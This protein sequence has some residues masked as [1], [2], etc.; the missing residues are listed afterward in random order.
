[1]MKNS[2]TPRV[3]FEQE[4]IESELETFTSFF[5]DEDTNTLKPRNQNWHIKTIESFYPELIKTLYS[6]EYSKNATKCKKTIS[7][8]FIKFNEDNKD[9]LNNA[10]KKFQQEWEAYNDSYFASFGELF[11]IS[12]NILNKEIKALVSI[13]PI[14]PRFLDS[15]SFNIYYLIDEDQFLSV[16]AHEV[17]HFLFFKKWEEVFFKGFDEETK[18]NERQKFNEPYLPWIIS[19]LLSPAF[20]NSPKISNVLKISNAR[21]YSEWDYYFIGDET[22]NDF[23]ERL[24]NEFLNSG[25]SFSD[26]LKLALQYGE[27]YKEV[28]FKAFGTPE[29]H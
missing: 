12:P 22:V 21:V 8:F 28:L 18:Q 1:M 15:Q 11:E 3:I 29:D 25:N 2:L 19:E 5:L 13:N 24:F 7:D 14:C 20:L 26:F 16:V 17:Q 4:P 10:I 9:D 27:K 6:D 23:F